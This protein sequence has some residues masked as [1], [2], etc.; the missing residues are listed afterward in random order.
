[1]PEPCS[2]PIRSPAAAGALLFLAGA[3]ILM[4]IITAEALYPGYSTSGNMISDL[5]ATM[6]PDSIILEP[7][8][9]I[10]DTA[11]VLAGLLIIAA[12]FSL[13][14]GSRNR[15]FTVLLALLGAGV[16]GVG[17]F[18]GSYG[19]IHALMALLAFV[20]GGLVALAAWRVVKP[21]FSWFS[22]ILGVFSLAA[23]GSFY[24]LGGSSPFMALG[25]G[26]LERWV[27][28]P[29]V[30]WITG[31]GGYLMGEGKGSGEEGFG[32]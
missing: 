25:P 4:G 13:S 31:Y 20:S 29:V 8:A 3:I 26:G 22:V 21:P 6:P 16:L 15:I 19:T 1:M 24:L 2:C 32:T 14:C 10:F 9:T 11:M 7:A 30:L 5:G 27:A 12:A 18:N 17:I 28:Y 23:L